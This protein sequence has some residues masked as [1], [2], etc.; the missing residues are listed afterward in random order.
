MA[1]NIDTNPIK[2]EIVKI[3]PNQFNEYVLQSLDLQVILLQ[4]DVFRNFLTFKLDYLSRY[5]YTNLLKP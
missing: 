5:I 3:K 1:E 4:K 2:M